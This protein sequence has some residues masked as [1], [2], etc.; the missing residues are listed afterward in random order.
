VSSGAALSAGAVPAQAWDDGLRAL[1]ADIGSLGRAVVAFS[2]GA[3]SALVARVATD[4]LGAER[5]LCVTAVSPSLA[6]EERAECAALAREW[7]LRW[8]EVVTDELADAAYAANDTDRCYH[9]KAALLGALAPL[10]A[11]E[12]ATVLLGV[13]LDDLGDHRPGQRAAAERGAHFPLVAAGLTKAEVRALSRRLGLRTWDKPAAACL[14][15]R[16][17]YGTPVTL[18]TLGAVARAESALRRLGFRQLR[19]RHYGDLARVELDPAE[20]AQAVHRRAEVVQAVQG[21]GYR[22][23]TLDLEG[24]RSGNL[25]HGRRADGAAPAT[26]PGA[27]PAATQGAT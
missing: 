19:V 2:G 13:N 20:L 22:Y 23:V 4:V 1:R 16:L 7:G 5:V 17:P 18:G 27:T 6:P 26:E 12:S 14:A 3:D 9:C 15:S 11:A 24:F 10:A 8:R 25:N 21:A